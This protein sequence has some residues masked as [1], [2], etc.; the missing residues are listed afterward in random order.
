LQ[1]L[2]QQLFP[3]CV[4][5]RAGR[6]ADF[7]GTL[8]DPEAEL[9]RSAVSLRRREFTAG[10]TCAHRALEALGTDDEPLL[11]DDDRVPRWPAGIVG[12]ITHSEH[13]CAA[14]VAHAHE[15]IAL[16]LD[17]EPA[18]P[19]ERELH[20]ALCTRD[21]L[22]ALEAHSGACET[23]VRVLFSAKEAFYKAYF[24]HTRHYLDFRDVRLALRPEEGVFEA[25]LVHDDAPSVLGQRCLHGRFAVMPG[26]VCT[27]VAVTR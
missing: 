4:H 24:P 11:R 18:G 21:E 17:L 15:V 13:H 1:E 5:V 19:I 9:V 2:I 12:S 27:A 23:W 26:W 6:I 22:D 7:Q 8:H 3:E 10:R 16:G 20:E 14:A 25:R